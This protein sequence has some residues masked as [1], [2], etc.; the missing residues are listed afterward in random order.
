M[1]RQVDR[2]FR[3]LTHLRFQKRKMRT[4]SIATATTNWVMS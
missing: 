3:S 1:Y 4:G 2:N